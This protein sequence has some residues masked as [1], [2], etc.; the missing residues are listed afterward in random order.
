MS[1]TL[2]L[3]LNLILEQNYITSFFE[4]CGEQR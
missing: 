1:L 3:E 2:N 4:G